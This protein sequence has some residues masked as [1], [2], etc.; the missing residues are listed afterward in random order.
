MAVIF[1]EKKNYKMI[2]EGKM[3]VRTT[4]KDQ[5]VFNYFISILT[6]D[7]HLFSVQL[8]AFINATCN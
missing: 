1:E 4:Y 5:S 7:F 2:R 6:Y 8:N 3:R